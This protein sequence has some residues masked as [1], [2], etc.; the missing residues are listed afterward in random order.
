M[1]LKK[2]KLTNFRN[3]ALKE[4]LFENGICTLAWPNRAGKTTI[5]DAISF[6]FVGKLYNGSSELASIKP[7][8]NTASIVSAEL[9]VK[10]SNGS[11]VVLKKDYFENWVKTRGTTD[12]VLS[13]HLTDCSING[14][15]KTAT[16]YNAEICK[17]FN[18]SELELVQ[19]I[20]NPYYFS[21]VMAWTKRRE[22]VNKVIGIVKPQDVYEIEPITKTVDADLSKVAY[23]ISDAKK[24][25]T[26]RLRDSNGNGY[27]KDESDLSAQISGAIVGT[28]ITEEDY[29]TACKTASSNE[30][31]ITELRAKKMG[32][33][34]AVL[35]PLRGQLQEANASLNRSVALD[36]AELGKKNAEVN[37]KIESLRR[38][39]DGVR[40]NQE[41]NRRSIDEMNRK[42]LL[43]EQIIKT[44]TAKQAEL[45]A[46]YLSLN[47]EEYKPLEAQNCPACG[48][49][50]NGE[51]DTQARA[52]FNL[53]KANTSPKS[54]RMA[55]SYSPKS[56]HST[57]KSSS[58]KRRSTLSAK[59]TK[60]PRKPSRKT[61]Q[62][63]TA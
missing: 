56:K 62:R 44:K 26:D 53:D 21:Q 38:T 46:K 14:I 32:M 52:K 18:V 15:K 29:T 11:E 30:N 12:M 20:I 25:L 51:L 60:S 7:I 2:L 39:T 22:L 8:T 36:N 9:T 37:D 48:F 58:A 33:N 55:R 23:K 10:L 54:S 28:F 1:E 63:F 50:L 17:M 31:R 19:A 57:M 6:L 13:G 61:T 45:R 59:P 34:D 35:Q 40:R 5:A 47:T 42:V 24:S 49:Q 43:N 4:L 3:F 41:S 16:E 27:K